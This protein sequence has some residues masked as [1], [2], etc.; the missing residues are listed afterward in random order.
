[1]LNE[2]SNDFNIIKSNMSDLDLNN[3]DVY[4]F[5]TTYAQK[6]IWFIN[7]LNEES[8]A[9]N[10]PLAYDISGELNTN[11]L[12][13]AINEII[14]RHES[15]RTIFVGSEHGPLQVVCPKMTI[16]IP[17]LEIND[18]DEIKKYIDK[19]TV[20][21]FSLSK[22]PLIRASIIK[23]SES[24]FV[25][26][27]NIH[28]II[29]DHISVVHF[30]KEMSK[31][32]LSYSTNQ[33]SK[34][35][36]PEFH[37]ADYA[38]WQGEW[39]NAEKLQTKLD[40]WKEQLQGK[41]EYLNLPHD[42]PRPAEQTMAGLEL[43]FEFPKTLSQEIKTLA[44]N[45]GLSVF[46]VLMAAYNIVLGRYA[47]QEEISVGVPFANRSHQPELE[48]I[49]GCFISTVPIQT[50][51]P[52]NISFKE[53]LNN[54]RKT[55]FAVNAHQEVPFEMIVEAL[56]PKRDPSFNPMFQVG[57]TFQEAPIEI[58]LNNLVATSHKL[59]NK[60]AK[61]DLYAWL[62]EADSKIQ[63]LLEYNTEL[64]EE[65]T[66]YRFL[67]HFENILQSIV[68]YPKCL[69][70]ELTMLSDIEHDVLITEWNNTSV[71]FDSPKLMHE[72][73]EKQVIS[74][75]SKIAVCCENK[76]LSYEE[77]EVQSNK[78]ANYLIAKDIKPGALVAVSIERSID[79]LV[80]CMAVLKTG[81]CY[82]SIDPEYPIDRIEYMLDDS[83]AVLLLTQEEIED[84]LDLDS[85]INSICI[86]LESS[87]IEEQSSLKPSV[88]ISS[89]DLAYIIYTSGSTGKPNGVMIPHGA[90]VNFLNSMSNKPGMS[91][92]D[93][94][95]AITTLSFDISVLELYLPL[96]V[97]AT[98]VIATSEE[99]E[100][101][102]DLIDLIEDHD[103]TVMQATPATWRLLLA[104]GWEGNKSLKV[105]CGG[106]ALPKDLVK[107]LLPKI[108]EFWNMYGPTETTVWS[109]CFQVKNDTSPIL[110]GS[111][112]ANTEFFV[113]DTHMEPVPVGVYGELYIAGEG[114]AK[115]YFNRE[116]L[117]SKRFVERTFGTVKKRLYKT[118][119]L[120]KF[121]VDG[122]LE[123]GQRIDNQVKVR[124]FRIEL[125]EIESALSE[126]DGIEH[127]IVVAREIRAGDLRLIAYI[128]VGS[129]HSVTATT[130][131]K[132]LRKTLPDYMLPQHFIELESMPL[133]PNGKI[134]RK[135]LPEITYD[136]GTSEEHKAPSTY[137][138]KRLADIWAD[139]LN[140]KSEE[141]SI[142]DN[143][144]E[145]GGHSLLSMQAIIRVKEI[146]GI[147][148]NP[149]VII[150]N[151]LE[152]MA[153]E[154]G[155]SE[156]NDNMSENKESD[157][158][159]KTNVFKKIFSR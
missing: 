75:G 42:K 17:V 72:L 13:K 78:L 39:Q 131:R 48:S 70:S 102:E 147:K 136:K 30:S 154:C 58:S 56:Q 32:Y 76:K 116:E 67:D 51:I 6:Q 5:P 38:V 44:K 47:R 87:K 31:L 127:S 98:V 63:G 35:D 40:F 14:R 92:N 61:F 152:N 69:V 97:G 90:A 140:M 134:N 146:T 126:I 133:M 159:V 3:E 83:K 2:S 53:L 18:E 57:F 74:S 46:I 52:E 82:I 105:L 79:M 96:H 111:P 153:K 129:E 100:D 112:I 49:M 15:F 21:P 8:S 29:L 144:F 23:R 12:I 149:R 157:Q 145:I 123:Y 20:L 59:H 94:L 151:S 128:V 99:T 25:F 155:F 109:S 101:G 9:Y 73:F 4:V 122:S 113:L 150:L 107:S 138:E 95:L 119:D 33:E 43:R 143:F 34:L 84:D 139:L 71:P 86:D 50:D 1:M 55:V 28:H 148:L 22:G 80:S 132:E 106:E 77:L 121:H 120:V 60:S 27:L 142:Y 85:Q 10:I 117:T 91:S 135:A 110:I 16:D 124:G 137:A 125:G 37:Y 54:I 19:A 118:G 36:E 156:D 11:A 65:G 158:T 88:K 64:Y 66:A 41:S 141:I 45:E 114:V 24:S 26:F 7:Q 115:G 62:W 103:I 89:E 108:G 81:A 104:S 130:L 93:T 68:K